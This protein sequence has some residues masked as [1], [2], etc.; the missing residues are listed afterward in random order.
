M[1]CH[2]MLYFHRVRCSAGARFGNLEEWKCVL[3]GVENVLLF[4]VNEVILLRL[5]VSFSVQVSECHLHKIA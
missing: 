5:N 2:D 4:I 1:I 3:F